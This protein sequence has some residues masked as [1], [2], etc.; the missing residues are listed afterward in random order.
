MVYDRI[1]TPCISDMALSSREAR[2]FEENLSIKPFARFG[3]ATF[4]ICWRSLAG[5][6]D[7][8]FTL[9]KHCFPLDGSKVT[10]CVFFTFEFRS[11]LHPLMVLIVTAPSADLHTVPVESLWIPARGGLG[12]CA[13]ARLVKLN[14][15]I[16]HSAIPT[17]RH[18]HRENMRSPQEVCSSPNPPQSLAGRTIVTGRLGKGGPIAINYTGRSPRSPTRS[19]AARRL[20]CG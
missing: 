3:K 16:A 7:I 15:A 14:P 2:C 5:L 6:V 10:N 13:A 18:F 12:C 1:D 8:R 9:T 4:A 20:D 17:G 19:S 11:Y